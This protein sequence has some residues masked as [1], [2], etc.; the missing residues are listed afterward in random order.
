VV[1]EIAAKR[2]SGRPLLPNAGGQISLQEAPV[3]RSR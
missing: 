1:R 2:A 3:A